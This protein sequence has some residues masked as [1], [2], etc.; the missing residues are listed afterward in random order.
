M[1]IPSLFARLDKLLPTPKKPEAVA[2]QA[3][4]PEK[5]LP[6]Q[7]SLPA[8][9]SRVVRDFSNINSYKLANELIAK[10]TKTK[11]YRVLED[12]CF[13]D[14]SGMLD[15]TKELIVGGKHISLSGPLWECI[16]D[17]NACRTMSHEVQK[18]LGIVFRRLGLGGPQF[19]V[20][21]RERTSELS[22]A[23]Q[24]ELNLVQQT[25]GA[26]PYD[27]AAWM[28]I[29]KLFLSHIEEIP[30]I[31]IS[32]EHVSLLWKNE[33]SQPKNSVYP[34]EYIR[35]AIGSLPEPDVLFTIQHPFATVLAVYETAV[36]DPN[37]I[38]DAAIIDHIKKMTREHRLGL[39]RTIK[40]TLGKDIT[41]GPIEALIAKDLQLSAQKEQAAAVAQKAFAV[42]FQTRDA[43]AE[44]QAYQTFKTSLSQE[45]K[46][47]IDQGHSSVGAVFFDREDQE[48]LIRLVPSDYSPAFEM[49]LLSFI[50]S[51]NIT[52][53]DDA[54]EVWDPDNKLHLLFYLATCVPLQE[55]GRFMAQDRPK[56]LAAIDPAT[57]SADNSAFIKDIRKARSTLTNVHLIE[58]HR[59]SKAQQEGRFYEVSTALTHAINSLKV[60]EPVRKLVLDLVTNY[61]PQ[62]GSL[63]SSDYII[64]RLGMRLGI[65]KRAIPSSCYSLVSFIWNSVEKHDDT[66]TICGQEDVREL[67]SK[68]VNVAQ[69]Q[70]SSSRKLYEK[71]HALLSSLSKSIE[72]AKNY[73]VDEKTVEAAVKE[74]LSYF[75]ITE[76][77]I[78]AE[79][80]PTLQKWFSEVEQTI[81]D[82]EKSKPAGCILL[83]QE[84]QAAISKPF[85]DWKM[86]Q[87]HTFE[88]AASGKIVEVV[89]CL[90]FQSIAYS[91]QKRLF[92]WC[93][94]MSER[95]LEG[96][97]RSSQASDETAPLIELIKEATG[98]ELDFSLCKTQGVALDPAELLS[99]M[100]SASLRLRN[101]KK[102]VMLAQ[103][104]KP[105]SQGLGP[106][107]SSGQGASNDKSQQ[108]L[109]RHPGLF[110]C[111]DAHEEKQ[112]HKAATLKSS[113]DHEDSLLLPEWALDLYDDGSY[114]YEAANRLIELFA[115]DALKEMQRRKL[116]DVRTRELLPLLTR[117]DQI[118]PVQ[119]LLGPFHLD[120]RAY[121]KRSVLHS[122]K[123]HAHGVNGLVCLDTGLGKTRVASEIL[124]QK[125]LDNPASLC[126]VIAPNAVKPQWKYEFERSVLLASLSKLLPH[127]NQKDCFELLARILAEHT[128]YIFELIPVVTEENFAVI[129]QNILSNLPRLAER[130]PQH[131]VD[132]AIKWLQ[133][134][135]SVDQLKIRIREY[136]TTKL[137]LKIVLE[138]LLPLLAQ[139]LQAHPIEPSFLQKLS[140]LHSAFPKDFVKVLAKPA[141]LSKALAERSS[142]IFVTAESQLSALLKQPEEA[143]RLKNHAPSLIV[144]DEAHQLLTLKHDGKEQIIASLMR[145]WQKK[146]KPHIVALTATPIVNEM[147]DLIQLLC[148]INPNVLTSNAQGRFEIAVELLKRELQS[149]RKTFDELND[150]VALDLPLATEQ[151]IK[152]ALFNLLWLKKLLFNPLIDKVSWEDD[153]VQALGKD[154]MPTV[155]SIKKVVEPLGRQMELVQSVVAKYKH[156]FLE[157]TDQIERCL[158]HPDFFAEEHIDSVIAKFGAMTCEQKKEFLLQSATLKAAF[159]DEGS[160]LT[161]T[162]E[163]NQKAL[164][165]VKHQKTAEF[166]RCIAKWKYKLD[167]SRCF[168]VHSNVAKRDQIIETFKQ[169]TDKAALLILLPKSGGVGLNFTNV[170]L[171]YMMTTEWTH[172]KDK[173][174]KARILRGVGERTIVSLQHKI[175][176]RKHILN[177][178]KKKRHFSDLLLP[179]KEM[180]L[181]A[182][183]STLLN[184]VEAMVRAQEK[185]VVVSDDWRAFFKGQVTKICLEFSK[186]CGALEAEYLEKQAQTST[187][188]PLSGYYISQTHKKLL[189]YRLI[190]MPESSE[191]P[192]FL[193]ALQIGLSQCTES[194]KET[195]EAYIKQEGS[196]D[197]LAKWVRTHFKVDE[198]IKEKDPE[199]YISQIIKRGGAV[200]IYE[201][202]NGIW[203]SHLKRVEIKGKR[204][205]DLKVI[206]ILKSDSSYYLLTQDFANNKPMHFSTIG[207][208]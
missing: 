185:N 164:I 33:R 46:A 47:K 144:I 36:Q 70:F 86:Q 35:Q 177:V 94:L 167:D 176:E 51:Q 87:V 138:V 180:T 182:T 135:K 112:L 19:N 134:T 18:A 113:N 148:L 96:I 12:E 136:T 41:T 119:D 62:N 174:A 23:C 179:S 93:A 75:K 77:E 85:V 9:Q 191:R 170:T 196:S 189:H 107:G 146:A 61:R 84:E 55:R 60:V 137:H 102:L 106:L 10:I 90:F 143:K 122:N 202:A 29:Q 11:A 15:I 42:P 154:K 67:R 155:R 116:E 72:E 4:E 186:N 204:R 184:T 129:K 26:M 97:V 168:V 104:L 111:E 21:A 64:A 108:E 173:Q 163:N 83:T 105:T 190:P 120:L 57:A 145:E 161:E 197:A 48:A 187:E 201:W 169:I 56:N 28:F 109:T 95:G 68:F 117:Y 99:L 171:N 101:G 50:D 166:V 98:Q 82:E 141:D 205:D 159:C 193:R 20:M 13:R 38:Q 54:K 153:E 156:S 126:L 103:F 127:Y 73:L 5:A 178:A 124:F 89:P 69:D 34:F 140:A 27:P 158:I 74:L 24:K 208:E 125:L 130:I 92:P 39:I 59:I 172:E 1:S 88:A 40:A 110:I 114:L 149:A 157:K 53:T 115:E 192:P 22:E 66:T 76:H 100:R 25:L 52:F 49:A 142:G 63:T 43:V 79:K 32:D 44:G 71:P 198:S 31:E 123:L 195:R 147:A 37:R 16:R 194:N 118:P 165:Y 91:D 30:L 200:Y 78:R 132:E 6:K 133:A 152:R 160:E 131:R 188:K 14:E 58:L 8:T 181:E 139:P 7:K 3:E 183:L 65:A 45:L 128:E 17:N 80:N 206:E 203:G 207:L 121:Q 199:A 162:L 2:I 175:P 81:R 151:T 150:A